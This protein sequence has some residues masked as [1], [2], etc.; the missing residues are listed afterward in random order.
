[1]EGLLEESIIGR[2][3]AEGTAAMAEYAQTK[4]LEVLQTRFKLG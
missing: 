4:M 3:S 1:M 2:T